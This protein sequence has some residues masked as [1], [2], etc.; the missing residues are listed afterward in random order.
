MEE[1]HALARTGRLEASQ[2]LDRAG[3]GVLLGPFDGDRRGLREGGDVETAEHRQVVVAGQADV[4]T[5]ANQL[6]AGVWL[7]PISDQVAEA[8]DLLDTDL[9]DRRE[10]ALE[11]GLVGVDVAD[12][13]YAQAAS[14]PWAVHGPYD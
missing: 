6:G 8:P 12:H 14:V 9:V 10:D 4:A 3:A 7:G 2:E 13:G 1:A 5:F 11:S